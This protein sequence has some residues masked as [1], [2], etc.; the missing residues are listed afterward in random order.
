[1]VLL[2]ECGWVRSLDG[3]SNGVYQDRLRLSIT[4]PNLLT[5]AKGLAQMGQPLDYTS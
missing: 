3:A 2:Y 5:N 1:V 4:Q